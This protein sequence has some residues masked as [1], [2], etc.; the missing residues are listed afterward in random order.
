MSIEWNHHL[1]V[2]VSDRWQ[3]S[4][5]LNTI[6]VAYNHHFDVYSWGKKQVIQLINNQMWKKYDTFLK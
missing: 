1:D 5:H 3:L 2:K 6:V 4:L